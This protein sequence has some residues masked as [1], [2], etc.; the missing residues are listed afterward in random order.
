MTPPPRAL[1]TGA[2]AGIGRTYAEHLA[3]TGHALVLVARRAD[4]LEALAATLRGAH[5]ID[6]EV[7]PADLADDAGVQRVVARIG[8]DPAIDLLE[9]P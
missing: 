3:R 5:G 7:L 6:V 9:A 4:R 2:S 1:V 8:A